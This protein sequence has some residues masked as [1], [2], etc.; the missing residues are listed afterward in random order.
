MFPRTWIYL[1]FH[2]MFPTEWLRFPLFLRLLKFVGTVIL[3]DKT[4]FSPL[5]PLHHDFFRRKG[6]N[7]R[8]IV[9]VHPVAACSE[10]PEG[11]VP[12]RMPEIENILKSI[13]IM[14]NVRVG[15][16]EFPVQHVSP[17]DGS[18]DLLHDDMMGD[19]L[20]GDKGGD[21]AVPRFQASAYG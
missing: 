18:I 14:G 8:R 9:I 20:P 13:G 17:C 2:E 6:K 1:E 15:F 21:I 11:A 16:P 10:H 3:A 7:L 12:L 4:L 5:V 19:L